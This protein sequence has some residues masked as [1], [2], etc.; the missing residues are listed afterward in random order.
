[1]GC[2]IHLLVERRIRREDMPD[3]W[4][5][6]RVIRSI[7]T[8]DEHPK[9][10]QKWANPV[11]RE[12][13]YDRF[14]ALAGVRGSGPEPRGMPTDASDTARLLFKLDGD[15]TPS[16]LPLAEASAIFL[17]TEYT[18]LS[19]LEREYPEYFYF[20]IEPECDGPVED[21]RLVFW[22]DS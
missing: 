22:F 11:A 14:A 6:V 9:W 3:Q 1:M 7:N 5:A 2:D 10:K 4:V 12:R 13:N 17:K 20:G 8:A 16:W 18:T 19:D 15:H 21:H